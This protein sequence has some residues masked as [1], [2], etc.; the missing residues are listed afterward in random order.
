MRRQKSQTQVNNNC[1]ENL[2]KA[3]K[4]I[5]RQYPSNN[6]RP[7][8][9]KFS[10]S[11]DW[12]WVPSKTGSFYIKTGRLE[13]KAKLWLAE[14]LLHCP[15]I[16]KGHTSSSY[17]F[18]ESLCPFFDAILEMISPSEFRIGCKKPITDNGWFNSGFSI[19][20]I[21]RNAEK[22]ANSEKNGR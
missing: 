13:P 20:K 18:G 4:S 8:N 21:R 14:P 9:Q 5:T 7:S 12:L 19:R 16:Y 2:K 3:R 10:K 6:H 15:D 1:L 11:G 22:Q 17:K